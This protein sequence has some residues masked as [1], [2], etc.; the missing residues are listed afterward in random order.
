MKE[1]PTIK[2][3]EVRT[4]DVTIKSMSLVLNAEAANHIPG[5]W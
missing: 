4:A 2:T 3:Q 1:V 5:S